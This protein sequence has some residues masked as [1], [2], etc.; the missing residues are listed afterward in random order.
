MLNGK[1]RKAKDCVKQA[2][3]LARAELEPR[4]TSVWEERIIAEVA[5]FN[6]AADTEFPEAAF[7]VG[8]LIPS[9]RTDGKVLAAVG[10]ACKLLARTV[11][12]VQ[13]SP[14]HYKIF[15]I[16]AA[17]EYHDGIV[18]AKLNPELKPYYL[19]LKREFT[20]LSLPE[21]RTLS[22][23]HSQ[24]LYRLLSSWQGRESVE[25]PL[26]QLHTLTGATQTQRKN[27]NEFSVRVLTPATQEINEKTGLKFHWEPIRGERGKKIAAVRFVFD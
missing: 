19:Q 12:K 24:Q 10:K 9:G 14:T 17:V 1:Q 8:R 23:M 2:N 18:S 7:M 22:K 27:F 4:A 5:A 26:E 16:F 11:Y 6:H 3:E 25:L 15:P 20:L 13:Y 21:F